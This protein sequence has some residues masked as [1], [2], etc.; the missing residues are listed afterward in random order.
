MDVNKRTKENFISLT[1][2][3]KKLQQKL[4]AIFRNPQLK[5]F[6]IIPHEA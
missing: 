4:R 3:K 6:G 5:F 2:N 1:F